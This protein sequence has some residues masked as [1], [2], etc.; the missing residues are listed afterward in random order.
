MRILQL[1]PALVRKH[2]A[3]Y[4]VCEISGCWLWNGPTRH[5]ENGKPETAYGVVSF[6]VQGANVKVGAHRLSYAD[7]HQT[8]P[9]E[10]FLLHRCDTPRCINPEHL[11]PGTHQDNMNDR[12]AKGRLV[13][14][15]KLSADEVRWVA[16]ALESKNDAEIAQMIGGKVKQDTIRQIRTG[17]IW[18]AI[19]GIECRRKPKDIRKVS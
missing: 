16:S 17:S 6:K 14:R 7:F 3:R 2:L 15:A 11:F 1:K 4:D 10:L 12:S 13:S 19:T 5:A 18:S 8:D 9:G